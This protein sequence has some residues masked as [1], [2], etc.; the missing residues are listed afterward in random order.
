MC[1][2]DG[3]KMGNQLY[4]N[5]VIY[6]RVYG[7]DPLD[8]VPTIT[9]LDAAG[10]TALSLQSRDILVEPGGTY[11]CFYRAMSSPGSGI[12][13]LD[14]TALG[15]LSA[16]TVRVTVTDRTG[17]TQTVTMPVGRVRAVDQLPPS[18]DCGSSH[19]GR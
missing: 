8:G 11:A 16:V 4:L 18:F 17:A 3:A 7:A 10:R 12:G 13:P 15:P 2:V 6:A 19:C 1:Q 9:V 5:P 14:V